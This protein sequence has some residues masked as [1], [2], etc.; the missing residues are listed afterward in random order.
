MQGKKP[1]NPEKIRNVNEKKK[2]GR[3]VG[4]GV[5]AGWQ[6]GIRRGMRGMCGPFGGGM[7]AGKTIF[8]PFDSERRAGLG[9]VCAQRETQDLLVVSY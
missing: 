8:C 4:E 5:N 3:E 9:G 2:E 1:R 6:G 7:D